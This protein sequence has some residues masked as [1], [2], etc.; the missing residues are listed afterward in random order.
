MRRRHFP[1]HRVDPT[2]SGLAASGVRL[3][4]AVDHA[5]RPDRRLGGARDFSGPSPGRV[6]GGGH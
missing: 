4:P 1:N 3:S 5:N 6:W 2:A